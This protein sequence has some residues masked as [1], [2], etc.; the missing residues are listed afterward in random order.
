MASACVRTFCARYLEPNTTGTIPPGGYRKKMKQ[1]Y[2]GYEWLTYLMVRDPTLHIRHGRND[3]NGEFRVDTFLVDGFDEEHDTVY[4]FNCCF[5]HGC[6]SCF[7]DGRD[8]ELPHSDGR[9]L[10]QA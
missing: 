2:V 6:L 1:S 8:V 9:T 4:E 10:Q 3:M 7:P 5:W